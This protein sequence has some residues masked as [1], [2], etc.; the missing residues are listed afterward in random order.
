[1]NSRCSADLPDSTVV[2]QTLIDWNFAPLILSCERKLHMDLAVIYC[3]KSIFDGNLGREGGVTGC[4][5]VALSVQA[6]SDNRSQYQ[7]KADE[8]KLSHRPVP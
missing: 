4:V 2:Y 6:A 7:A 5:D 1:M 8:G 3:D